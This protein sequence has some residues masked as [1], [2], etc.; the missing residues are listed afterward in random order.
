MYMN[1]KNNFLI[2]FTGINNQP[3]HSPNPDLQNNFDVKLGNF[4]I[5]VRYSKNAVFAKSD[6]ENIIILL[7][8]YIY[9][10]DLFEGTSLEKYLIYK[11]SKYKKDFVKYLNGSFCLFF[12]QKDSGEVYFATDR[13]N[14]RKIFKYENENNLIFST[15][16]NY[17]PLKEC[18]LSYAGAACYL[19]NS[20]MLNDLTIFDEI[21]KLDRSSLYK[22]TD[23]K[24]VSEKYWDYKFTNEYKNRSETDLADELHQ[25]YLRALTKIV[26]GKKN[27]FIS[28]SGGYDSRG[29]AAMLKNISGRESGVMCISHNFGKDYNDTDAGIAYQTAEKLGFNFKLLNSYNGNPF[30]TLKYNAEYGHGI[31]GFC[32]ESDAWE[33]VNEDINGYES[34]IMLTGDMND[35]TYVD[36]HGNK[37]RALEKARICEPSFLNQF[38]HYFSA[39]TFKNLFE[40]WKYEYQK[41]LNKVSIY[42]DMIN[43]L[44]FLYMD[45]LIPN[46]YGIQREC[47]HIPFIETASPYYDNDVLDFIQKITPEL[48]DR[49]KLH[50][51]TL[52]KYYPEV[53]SI[54]LPEGGWGIEPAW[55][56]EIIKFSDIFIN[57]INNHLSRLDEI[58]SPVL[59]TDSLRSLNERDT[60]IYKRKTVL[61][62]A[63]NA[64]KKILP[65]YHRIIEKLPGGNE[66]TRKAGMYVN[67]RI[68][69]HP[70]IKILILRFYLSKN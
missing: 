68:T 46:L 43:L 47:F 7:S 40:E 66:L 29:V 35:G 55:T 33:Q 21:K 27:I 59:I 4:N 67:P 38:K 70:L 10:D 16:I 25:L 8:G 6:N 32:T 15:D 49:K 54:N 24:I 2:T 30:H 65:D 50:I 42:D 53:F 51:A 34:S 62:R 12:I 60:N 64:L 48:R 58:I 19:I 61:N 26:A 57:D 1:K 5:S 20:I 52:E 11:Y 37:K 18:K 56:D 23:S 28:L 44:D 9:Q 36:F 45:Q 63:H 69:H 17:L 39:E 13:L 31:A 22:I 41:I 3:D 14:T